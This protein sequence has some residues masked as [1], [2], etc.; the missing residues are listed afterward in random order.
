MTDTEHRQLVHLRYAPRGLTQRWRPRWALS[1]SFIAVALIVVIVTYWR[2]IY[3]RI[4]LQYWQH[5]CMT[6]ERP[7]QETIFSPGV[8]APAVKPVQRYRDLIAPEFRFGLAGP[9]RLVLFMHKRTTQSGKVRL[10]LVQLDSYPSRSAPIYLLSTHVTPGAWG[11]SPKSASKGAQMERVS[12]PGVGVP[13]PP[14]LTVYAAQA[15]A[16]DPSHFTAKYEADGARGTIHGWLV[17]VTDPL[18]SHEDVQIVFDVT[19]D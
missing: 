5:E 15:D 1:T 18:T 10:V 9:H 2:S 17:D 14:S 19:P 6:Y 4:Q 13:A 16:Q 7:L 11:A 3:H 8:N 12:L